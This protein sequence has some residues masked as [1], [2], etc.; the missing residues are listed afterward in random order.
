MKSGGVHLLACVGEGFLCIYNP[1][2]RTSRKRFAK[3][4]LLWLSFGLLGWL[5]LDPIAD[6]EWISDEMIV[7]IA[8]VV[9]VLA[10]AWS[11]ALFPMLAR[12]FHDA[13]FSGAWAGLALLPMC[14]PVLLVVAW[15]L[16][17]ARDPVKHAAW[18]SVEVPY[19]ARLD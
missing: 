9:G 15:M 6:A 17:A 7:V 14:T 4:V 3:E 19:P 10:A 16:P 8:R 1:Q 11:A 5:S 12:R 13:G 18:R 2:C